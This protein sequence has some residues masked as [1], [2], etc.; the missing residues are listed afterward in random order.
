MASVGKRVQIVLD[1]DVII[2]FSK[3]NVLS[4]LPNIFPE[5]ELV[6]LD[7]VYNELLSVRRQLD[8]QIHFFQNMSLIKFNPVG[9]MLQEYARLKLRFGD[10]ESACMVYCRYG[11]EITR[12]S[13][14]ITYLTTLDFLY[15]AWTRGHIIYSKC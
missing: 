5:Y 3:G 10:G 11:S 8:S 7:K 12:S 13:N 6:V 9:E 4:L 2:H 15:Y 14:R 1:A